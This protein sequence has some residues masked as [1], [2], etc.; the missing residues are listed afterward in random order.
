MR[1]GA[2]AFS[3]AEL[4]LSFALITVVLLTVASLFTAA[5]RT[6]GKAGRSSIGQKAAETVLVGKLHAIYKG[7][8]PGLTKAN[9]F[10]QDAPPNPVLE[11]SLVLSGTEYV[12]RMDYQ[13]VVDGAGDPLG[14]GL[15]ENR[16]KLVG[17]TC[18]WWSADENQTRAGTGKQ[19]VR[20]QR[21]VNEND[22]F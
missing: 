22:Q 20:I 10:A 12:Y 18:W 1:R 4:V 17:V 5:F 15:P 8:H 2:K 19:S 14:R 7:V 6:Q 11:G 3:L 16:L 9:F 21:L 13:T